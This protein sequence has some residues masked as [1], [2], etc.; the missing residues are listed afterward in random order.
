MSPPD[1]STL[2]RASKWGTSIYGFERAEMT[3]DVPEPDVPHRRRAIWVTAGAVAVVVIVVLAVLLI[4]GN[5]S[6]ATPGSESGQA[7]SGPLT[8]AEPSQQVTTPVPSVSIPKP[9]ATGKPTVVPTQETSTTSAPLDD[10]VGLASGVEVRV[11][12]IESVRGEAQGPGEIAGPAVRVTVMVRNKSDKDISMDMA[13]VNVYY[14]AEK[15]P[16]STLSGPGA[17][18]LPANL[19]AGKSARGAYVFSVPDNQ[20]DHLTVEFSYSTKAPTVIFS[21]KA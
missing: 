9:T 19:A 10:K 1:A 20:R 2:V 21:G 13:L 8:D 12:E 18:P 5:G 14:G 11:A 6:G 4:R 17:V 3:D 16:A 15:T 7:G